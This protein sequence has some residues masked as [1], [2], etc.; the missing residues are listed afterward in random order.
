MI[1][2]RTLK[3]EISAGK[4]HLAY[5]F[6]GAD[7]YRMVE[8]EKYLVRSFLPDLQRQINSCKLDGRRTSCADLIAEL[9][10]LPM[11][12]DKQV[13]I[14]SSFQS[15]KP[16]E[17]DAVLKLLTP[18]DPN[19]TV[20]FST[21]AAKAPKRTSAFL[22]KM[23]QAVQVV[24]FKKLAQAD[25]QKQIKKRLLAEE[26][27]IEPE[28]LTLL[29][30][31][32][33]GNLGPME[34]EINKLINYRQAGETVTVDDIGAVCSD[35]ATYNIFALAD[36]IVAGRTRTVLKMIDRLLADGNTPVAIASLLQ[37]HFISLYLVKNSRKPLGRRDFLIG[38][39]RGQAAQYDNAQL[40]KIIVEIAATDAEFRQ[41]ALKPAAALQMLALKMISD[42]A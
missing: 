21:P 1:T 17:I 39:F 22:K 12:G 38:K 36:E 9:S 27:G 41:Q 6:F 10:N 34:S 33:A 15:Y 29:S 14:V 24:E 31:L 18:P 16:T 32:V 25:I 7:D 37:Q 26:I 40:E 11:L 4:F 5:Y 30:E 2:P 8:A 35:Y 42:N 28:A 20:I 13:V 3:T 23:G 19:R